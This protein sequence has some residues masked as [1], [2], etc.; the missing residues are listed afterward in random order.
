M[1]NP[2]LPYSTGTTPAAEEFQRDLIVDWDDVLNP[3]TTIAGYGITD[4]LTS[5]VADLA[6][7]AIDHAH[8]Y[9]EITSRPTTI[10]GYGITDA[11]DDATADATY[12]PLGHAHAF[13]DLTS[14]PTTLAGYGITDSISVTEANTL[15][16]SSTHSHPFSAISSKP[17][18]L[19][20]YGITT[21]GDATATSVTATTL[22]ATNGL[23]DNL[24]LGGAT[25][26]TQ[27]YVSD[28]AQGL[29]NKGASRAATTA[30]I[31]LSGAQTIDGVAIVAGDRV[32]VKNQTTAAQ[33]GIYVAA[34]GAW[35]RATNMDSWDEVVSAYTFIQSGTTQTGTAWNV[36]SLAGGT[37]GTTAITWEQFSSA[38]SYTAGTGITLA[39]N[40]FSLATMAASTIKGSVAGGTPADL[41]ATQVRTI[42][43]IGAMGLQD[44]ASVAITGGSIAG[45]TDL[46]I[47]DGGTG[48]SNA[49]TARVNLG[50]QIGTNVQAH[51]GD[52]TAIAALTSAADRL[53]YYSGSGTAALATF[54]TFG[55][56]LV[57]DANAAAARTTLGLAI[58]SDVQAY[59]PELA[60]I[61]A[62]TSASDRLPYFTGSGTAALATFTA[63]G[64][65]LVNDADDT[66]ARSTL[67]LGTMATQG[68]GAVAISGGTI[69]APYIYVSGTH[70]LGTSL[71]FQATTAPFDV[72]TDTQI[73]ADASNR[74]SLGKSGSGSNIIK[75]DNSLLSATRIYSFPD[76]GGT[77]ALTSNSLSDFANT[78]GIGTNA[79][80]LAT[81]TVAKARQ[82]G[83]TAYTDAANAFDGSK[84]T[85][86]GSVN[87]GGTINPTTLTGAGLFSVNSIDSTAFSAAQYNLNPNIPNDGR[88]STI[89]LGKA[90][91]SGNAAHLS[92]TPRA[93]VADTSLN[94]GFHSFND[95]MIL[96]RNGGL[97]LGNPAS[98]TNPGAGNLSITGQLA[99]ATVAATGAI[100]GASITTTGAIT[101]SSLLSSVSATSQGLT[102]SGAMTGS[103]PLGNWAANDI[104]ITSDNTAY[105]AGNFSS[106]LNIGHRFGGAAK[107]GGVNALQVNTWLTTATSASNTQRHYVAG[108][109]QSIA[110]TSDG[111]T[112]LAAGSKGGV[113]AINPSTIARNG[114]VNLG[115]ITG[116][117][118]NVQV[119][120]G[121]S[122]RRKSLL[123]LVHNSLD[124][125]QGKDWDCVL[126]MSKQSGPGSRVGIAF[127]NM[128]ASCPVTQVGQS[129]ND[130]S[131]TTVST[132]GTLIASQ[133][134]GAIGTA[135]DFSSYTFNVS[136]ASHAHFKFNSADLTAL[137]GTKTFTN[138]ATSKFLKVQDQS[139]TNYYIPL[140]T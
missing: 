132:G 78:T 35:S 123:S 99:S 112:D 121:A 93:T 82:Y 26:A 19:A 100:T 110:E 44:S 17:T 111:G 55:R 103:S 43:G 39:G 61:G 84:N 21:L 79:S 72:G 7:A 31:T 134:T 108:F 83:N 1:P 96:F 53:P 54:T 37:L 85:F 102:I 63:F 52:L 65:S 46:G 94:F 12:A 10:A 98:T 6:Y 56:A 51:S 29:V 3:P 38:S 57:D 137:Q 95:R 92:F 23:F 89:A 97:S 58:G 90:F 118:F 133:G 27:Q 138:G 18:T 139:G 41:T 59:A 69:S 40:Q 48:A 42:L 67:G 49:A 109:F 77:L 129:V 136:H 126:A 64:R 105:G 32:L 128:H 74:I 86:A 28:N 45:I 13:G 30:N 107:T 80:L 2:I 131:A 5:D 4:A 75:F 124:A 114:A 125:V 88:G 66:E 120:T 115:L 68:A 33:N 104:Q 62:L 22:T 24:T 81:G 130:G 34:A 15:Y 87:I 140:Y 25:V 71:R 117:E 101:G 91:S 70:P 9:S 14:K 47:P 113:F 60:A 106:A 16:A 36:T 73:Y 127:T 50:L 11:L 135:I 116:A 122:T 8:A 76:A 20:G 119:E